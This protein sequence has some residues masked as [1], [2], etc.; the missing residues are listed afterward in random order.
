MNDTDKLTP[1]EQSVIEQLVENTGRH[2][3]DSGDYYGRSWQRNQGRD[4]KAEQPS[5]L[6][7]SHGSIDVTHNV[8]HWLVERVD[9]QPELDAAF[10]QWSMANKGQ[11]KVHRYDSVFTEPRKDVPWP[12]NAE[13][14]VGIDYDEQSDVSPL[15]GYARGIYGDGEPF[16]HN[17]Y[18]GE[19]LVS[20][21]LQYVYFTLEQDVTLVKVEDEN[22]LDL[23][24]LGDDEDLGDRPAVVWPSGEY[25]LLQVHGGCDVRGGYTRPRVYSVSIEDGPSILDN[26]R[27]ELT[28]DAS[29]G[30]DTASEQYSLPGVD[31]P[32]YS[33]YVEPHRWYTDDGCNWYSD[34]GLPDIAKDSVVFVDT[35]Q[36]RDEQAEDVDE[37][38]FFAVEETNT[39]HCFCGGVLQPSAY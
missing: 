26:A 25:V 4:F 33:R 10:E 14:F 38:T 8:F 20:Q 28:C 34:S 19:D 1:T 16:V 5:I 17:T 12:A 36:D 39:L 24:P 18:N 3:L 6:S 29:G 31:G 7:V 9:Y 30:V 32:L 37:G 15:R 22:G 11:Q 21:T 23:V 27:A 2:M 13:A 35:E